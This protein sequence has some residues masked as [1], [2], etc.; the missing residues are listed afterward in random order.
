MTQMFI[1]AKSSLRVSRNS[2]K[3]TSIPRWSQLKAKSCKV[4]L[5]AA[6]IWVWRLGLLSIRYTNRISSSS[7]STYAL[8]SYICFMRADSILQINQ[9]EDT[10]CPRLLLFEKNNFFFPRPCCLSLSVSN[11]IHLLFGF[12]CNFKLVIV[13]CTSFYPYALLTK[14]SSI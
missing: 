5:S 12:D 1:K 3:F 11:F 4:N 2:L 8:H 7:S 6:E 9:C 14:L 13:G 10:A